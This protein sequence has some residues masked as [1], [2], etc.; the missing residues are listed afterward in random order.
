MKYMFFAP[1]VTRTLAVVVFSVYGHWQYEGAALLG[2]LATAGRPS[3][4][5][6]EEG[7]EYAGPSPHGPIV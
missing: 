1:I 2:G 5:A 3:R 6:D 4:S 7:C